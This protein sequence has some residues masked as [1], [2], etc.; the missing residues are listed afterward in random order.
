MER[1]ASLVKP[2]RSYDSSRRQQQALRNRANV[3]EA[4]QR[5]FLT[6]G[7]AATTITALAEAANVSVE[8]IYK[9]FGGK[10]GLVRAI[11]ERGLAGSGPIPAQYRSDE[12]SELE[13][14]P[15]KVIENWGTLST[16]VAPRA[17]PILLLIRLA[18]ASDLEMAALQQEVDQ[19]RL[20][21]M[22][23]NA[24]TLYERG[25][26]RESVSLEEARDVLWA[27][28]SPELYDLLVLRQ[29]WPLERYGRFIAEGIIAALLPPP[30][31]PGTGQR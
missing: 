8:T 11:W 24:R 30:R 14:D 9:A 18:A 13:A 2:K 27:Y 7:Y 19:D 16:E 10:R 3:L 26:V 25:H 20:A 21:R 5:L 12:M 31:A 4:A 28:S 15:R 23:R 1:N 6:D 17:A 22:E 29:G